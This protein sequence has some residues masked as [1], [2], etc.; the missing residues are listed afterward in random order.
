[1]KPTVNLQHKRG[2]GP[3]IAALLHQRV[4]VGIPQANAP[5]LESEPKTPLQRIKSAFGEGKINNAQLMY[6]HTNGSPVHNIPARPVIEPALKANRDSILPEM[7]EAAKTALK[8]NTA[9]AKKFM[10]R[11]GMAGQNAAKQWFHDARNGW[12]P[13]KRATIKRKGSS[14]ILIDTGAL[15]NSIT[16]VMGE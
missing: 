12:A 3:D 15:R 1:M 5:R 10:R 7:E 13:L 16:W 8:G 9:T 2:K 4:Y 11:A 6:I 14:A